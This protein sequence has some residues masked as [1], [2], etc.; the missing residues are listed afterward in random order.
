MDE[1]ES[2]ASETQ[3]LNEIPV[4]CSVVSDPFMSCFGIQ[5]PISISSVGNRIPN[6][7]VKSTRLCENLE[8][9]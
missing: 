4:S 9:K 1:H 6:H 3:R 7:D 2:I 5:F 8:H